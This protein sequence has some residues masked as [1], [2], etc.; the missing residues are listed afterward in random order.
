MLYHEEAIRLSDFIYTKNGIVSN[1][2]DY[3]TSLPCLDKVIISSK[4]S[5]KS[6][7]KKN[8]ELMQSALKMIDDK[9]FIRDAL[10]TEMREGTAFYYFDIRQGTQ[11]RNKFMTDYDVENIVEI[12]EIGINARII[13]LPWRYTKIVG[14]KN[15][16]YVLAFNLRYFDDFTGEQLDRKLKKLQKDMIRSTMDWLMEI[17]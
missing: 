1:S 4:N 7:K 9:M 16:R 15:G 5:T 6:K 13:T 8:K 17:G 11:D 12:N 2:I 10:H 3:M 14:K